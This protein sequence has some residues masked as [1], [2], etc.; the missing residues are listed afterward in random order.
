MKYLVLGSSGQIGKPLSDFLSEKDH[1]VSRF[2]IENNLTQDLRRDNVILKHEL[3]ECDF[4]FFLAFDIGGSKYIEAKQKDFDFIDNNTAIML[5][6]FRTLQESKKPFIFAS[7]QMATMTHSSYGTL[8]MLGEHYTK[9]LGGLSVRFWNVYGPESDP[10]K[11]HVITDFIDQAIDNE[12]ISCRTTGKE[13][14]QFLYV[15]DCCNILYE[16][17]KKYINIDK[18]E[19]IHVSSFEWHSIEEISNVVVKVCKKLTNKTVKQ[20]FTDLFDNVQ[21]GTYAPPDDKFKKFNNLGNNHDIEFGITKMFEQRL[22]EKG[23]KIK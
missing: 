7:S 13:Q 5:N 8:K 14:R 2:D 18:T 12:K 21:N 17:S 20:E 19:A 22:K 11:F 23:L 15:E 10:E 1:Y 9:A 16:L 6:T 3:A 4:V